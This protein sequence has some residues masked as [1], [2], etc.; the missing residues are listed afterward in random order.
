MGKLVGLIGTV[1]GK[2][3]T[4]VYSKG[5][6]GLT[7]GRAWQPQVNDPKTTGQTNQRLKMN[8]V[9]RLSQVTPAE[10][11]LSLGADKRERRAAYNRNLLRVAIVENSGSAPIAKINPGDLVF[12]K[13]GEIL[14]AE[15]TSNV[16]M[17]AKNLT[18]GLTL[19]DS[20]M[21]DKYGERIILAIVDPSD[22]A[23]YSLVVYKDVV[24]D[25]TTEITVSVPFGYSL[26]NGTMVCVYRVPFVLNEE[27]VSMRTEG[28]A[29][30]G[31][32]IIAKGELSNGYVK[33]WGASVLHSKEV[34]TQA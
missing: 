21:V 27:G 16:A 30:D 20:S 25:K 17:T 11:L 15:V 1:S 31:T 3:G 29:N 2:I 14:R 28:L 33:S 12:S 10:V 5:K 7:Y 34:F 24:F 13:G 4:V 26:E 32:D 19:A 9:G 23:G 6:N 8:L 22:K 18:M